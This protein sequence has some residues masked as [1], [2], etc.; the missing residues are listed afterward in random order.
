MTNIRNYIGSTAQSCTEDDSRP[1]SQEIPCPSEPEDSLQ[2]AYEPS[3]GPDPEPISS[4][5]NGLG[6][7]HSTFP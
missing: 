1:T 3:S 6:P 2:H 7:E 4:I 5:R